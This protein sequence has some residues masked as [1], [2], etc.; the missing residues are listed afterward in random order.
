MLLG[1]L[2]RRDQSFGVWTLG[3]R[4]KSEEQLI[5]GSFMLRV[6]GR[7]CQGLQLSIGF[8]SRNGQPLR[9]FLRLVSVF[10]GLRI[11]AGPNLGCRLRFRV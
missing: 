5:C 6:L 8:G 1:F 2:G 7:L 4:Q 10:A 11:S 9:V 3:L